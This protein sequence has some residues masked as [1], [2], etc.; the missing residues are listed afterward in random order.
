MSNAP[1]Q[2]VSSQPGAELARALV[3]A[4]SSTR[5][6]PHDARNEYHRYAYT[7]PKQSSPS[8]KPPSLRTGCP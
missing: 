3:A 4:Q 7:S 8:A 6:I 2:P 1:T 5:A